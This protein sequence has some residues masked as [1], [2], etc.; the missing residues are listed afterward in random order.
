MRRN[1]LAV[2][3]EANLGIDVERQADRAAQRDL[4]GCEPADQR[5]VHVEVGETDV[6]VDDGVGF[7]AFLGQVGR[8]LRVRHRRLGEIGRHRVDQV[9]LAVQESQPARLTLF[10]HAQLDPLDHRQAPALETPQQGLA[11]GIVG[12]GLCIEV[13]LTVAWVALEHDQRAAPP[14]REHERPGA[15]RVRHEVIVITLDHF[16]RHGAEDTAVGQPMD[17]PRPRLRQRETQRVTVDRLD[18]F[19]LAVVVEGPLVLQRLVAQRFQAEHAV[20]GEAVVGGAFER[21]VEKPLEAVDIVLRHQLALFASKGRVV[22]EVDAG[23]ELDRP[24]LEVG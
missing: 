19:D 24:D 4:V 17:E 23:F 16:T 12:V 10:D 7:D 18:A 2:A 3:H 21:R 14:L 9:D 11:F 20:F 1:A 13:A 15:H 6:G 5:V 22:G 8:E